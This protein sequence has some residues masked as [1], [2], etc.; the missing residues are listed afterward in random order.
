M[1]TLY[2]EAV[3]NG[4]GFHLGARLRRGRKHIVREGINR[5]KTHPASRGT[6]CQSQHAEMN[7]LVAARPGDHLEVKRWLKDGTLTMA[8][9][10]KHCTAL[11]LQKKI[12]TVTYSDWDGNLVTVRA[13]EL[14]A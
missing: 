5:K 9:P 10:C 2:Y 14:A 3:R 13:K 4:L 7:V 6:P 8:R 12:A 1:K 11:I